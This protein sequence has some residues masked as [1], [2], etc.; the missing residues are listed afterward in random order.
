MAEVKKEFKELIVLY[1]ED[2]L[3]IQSTLAT[4][5]KRRFKEVITANDEEEGLIAFK[6]HHGKIDIIITDIQM[7]KLNGLKMS[8]EIKRINPMI[9]IIITTA[10][11]DVDLMSKAIN[12]VHVE[13]YL[14]KPVD[15]KKLDQLILEATQK[16]SMYQSSNEHDELDLKQMHHFLE[17]QDNLIAV[18]SNNGEFIDVNSY[19]LQLI[20]VESL[21]ELQ[22]SK[23]CLSQFFI[24][25]KEF[26]TKEMI[27]EDFTNFIIQEHQQ[28]FRVLMKDELS[29]KNEVFVL[30]AKEDNELNQ[31]II[32]LTKIT[33]LNE[34]IDFY[35]DKASK[36]KSTQVL[37]RDATFDRLKEL[38]LEEPI[39]IQI[40]LTNFSQLTTM[41]GH[42]VYDVILPQVAAYL[43]IRIRDNDIIGR[44]DK[45]SFLIVLML[46]DIGIAK[47][48]V[49]MLKKQ[50]EAHSFTMNNRSLKTKSCCA[51]TLLNNE[52]GYQ[53]SVGKL[54]TAIQ[55]AHR[56]GDVTTIIS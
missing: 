47:K 49:D 25:H 56:R 9:P 50:L 3:I 30:S 14:S 42:D 8:R 22:D 54:E 38:M 26:L 27:G 17:L 13:G 46:S 20:G 53:K 28:A 4:I 51:L 31:I 41:Y 1:V 37:D 7:P 45:H 11:N 36:D 12:I 33:D 18:L 48:K 19:L 5:L 43:Q 6:Q 21:S 52:V 32:T 55:N 35:K 16:Q 29:Q 44:L 40:K 2:E 34:Q 10:F 24:D 39:L 23:K 15:Y